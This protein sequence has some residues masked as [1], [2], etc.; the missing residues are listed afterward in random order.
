VGGAPQQKKNNVPNNM[1]ANWKVAIY[2]NSMK[3]VIAII[4]GHLVILT[5]LF[6]VLGYFRF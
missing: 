6:L 3:K 1:E 2:R 5:G 4:I